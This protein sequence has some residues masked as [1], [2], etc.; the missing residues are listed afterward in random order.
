MREMISDFFERKEKKE[1]ATKVRDKGFKFPSTFSVRKFNSG[2]E[3]METR[4][5]SPIFV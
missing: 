1:Q 3:S 4:E 2:V 5:D